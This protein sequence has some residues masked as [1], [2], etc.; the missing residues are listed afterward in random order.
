MVMCNLSY[1]EAEVTNL[2]LL[3]VEERVLHLKHEINV[4]Y[5]EL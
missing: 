4:V 2:E 1:V 3:Y 5:F